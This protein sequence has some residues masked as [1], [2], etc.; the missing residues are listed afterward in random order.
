[1]KQSVAPYSAAVENAQWWLYPLNGKFV[2]MARGLGGQRLMVPDDDLI[3]VFTGWEL[4]KD[5]PEKNIWWIGCCL[6]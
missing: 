3:V 1:V 2:W 5:S 4:L 6:Q